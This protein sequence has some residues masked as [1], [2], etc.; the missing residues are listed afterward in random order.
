[1]KCSVC[2]RE[3][4]YDPPD[5]KKGHGEYCVLSRFEMIWGEQS[6]YPTEIYREIFCSLDC[7]N[8]PQSARIKY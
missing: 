1:M 3:I 4:T 6:V 5:T 8:T 7:L 2:Q